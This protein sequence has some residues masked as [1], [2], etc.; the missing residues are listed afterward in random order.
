MSLN[1]FLFCLAYSDFHAWISVPC[2][3]I[4]LFVITLGS[5]A[6][7]FILYCVVR[8][9]IGTSAINPV[10]LATSTK[11]LLAIGTCIPIAVVMICMPDTISEVTC[12]IQENITFIVLFGGFL[13]PALL[14]VV[15]CDHARQQFGQK[16]KPAFIWAILAVTTLLIVVLGIQGLFDAED[17]H[18]CHLWSR[19]VDA[20]VLTYIYSVVIAA[21]LSFV[22][23]GTSYFFIYKHATAHGNSERPMSDRQTEGPG[24]FIYCFGSKGSKL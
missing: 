19:R 20:V 11:N 1:A 13:Y 5:L 21:F 9:K 2:V 14:S 23:M 24:M 16:R 4:L 3:I 18:G 17:L 22:T 6:N 8:K 10:L 7:S 15:Q 12:H